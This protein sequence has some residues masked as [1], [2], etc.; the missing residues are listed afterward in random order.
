MSTEEVRQ[1]TNNAFVRK[2]AIARAV[3]SDWPAILVHDVDFSILP[4]PSPIDLCVKLVSFW[5]N[6]PPRARI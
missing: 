2:A 5:R 4:C 6:A 3:I 1:L